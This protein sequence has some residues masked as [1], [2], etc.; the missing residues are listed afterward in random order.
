MIK[1]QQ[2]WIALLVVCTFMWLMQVSTMPV[3]AAGT[4]EQISSASAEQGPD[5]Y[6]AVSNKAAPAKKKSMLPIIL[7]GVAATATIV[8]VLFLF[9]LKGYDIIGSWSGQMTLTIGGSGT[10]TGHAVFSG[11]KKSGT[12]LFS[13]PGLT[14]APGT[15]TV[16]GK[17]VNFTFTD[18]GQ[19]VN[20]TG[21]F[22][23]KDTMSGS[24]NNVTNGNWGGLWEFTRAGSSAQQPTVQSLG[25]GK[26][27]IKDK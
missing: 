8:A 6:E 2:K 18:Y 7:I 22:D 19:T 15:F 17:D 14:N 11:K 1:K 9:V 10:F 12:L 3:A 20:F 21:V 25:A 23:T 24:W 4:T 26:S 27:V 5:Y 13:D 16:S